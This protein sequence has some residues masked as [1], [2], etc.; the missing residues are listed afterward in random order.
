MPY[1]P[2]QSGN[3]AGRPIGSRN[4]KTLLVEALLEGDG[5]DLAHRL[6]QK[7]MTGD[8]AALKLCFDRLLAPQRERPVP[9]PL[10][11]LTSSHDTVASVAEIQAGVGAGTIT[12]REAMELLRLVDK[13][14]QTLGAAEAKQ[15]AAEAR[16]VAEEEAAAGPKTLRFSWLDGT[17]VAE[18]TQQPDG[19]YRSTGPSR[20]LGGE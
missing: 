2:G 8:P 1:A 3:P 11:P 14:A 13:M 20:Q 5:E 7:A 4:R 10:P 17:Q 19:T 18:L 15:A 16:Q 6:V 12:P 9:F